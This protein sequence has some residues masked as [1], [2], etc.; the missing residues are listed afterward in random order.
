VIRWIIAARLRQLHDPPGATL[1]SEAHVPASRGLGAAAQNVA[2]SEAAAQNK[3]RTSMLGFVIG[4]VCLIGLFNV[5]RHRHGWGGYG[6]FAHAGGCGG[7]R[8]YGDYGGYERQGFGGFRRAGRNFFLRAA[9]ER[10]D[11]T[12]GQEKVIREA[13]DELREAGRK[14][15]SEVKEARPEVAQA[16]R[17]EVFDENAV[18]GVVARIEGATE[19]LR[20]AAIDAFAKIH[21]VLDERQRSRL[22]DFVESGPRRREWL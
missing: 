19:S 1:T 11:T 9:F 3:E 18:G 2:A 17:G 12:P 16:L 22:A 7:H 8:G 15:K 21:G 14:A 5:I 4:T 13:I 20:K 6:R 10:L